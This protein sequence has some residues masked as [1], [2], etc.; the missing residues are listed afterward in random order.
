MYL[1][2]VLTAL[3][4]IAGLLLPQVV[5]AADE[6][7]MGGDAFSYNIRAL[8]FS[9]AQYPAHS[10]QNPD[11]AFLDLHRY[12]AAIELRP[13]LFFDS[14][15]FGALFKPRLTSTSRW[16]EDGGS[17]GGRDNLTRAFVNEW[18]V[19]AKPH[20][21]LFLSFGKEK[22]LWGPS[23]LAS[24]SNILFKDTER[25][26]PK[27]EVEGIHLVRMVYLPSAALTITALSETQKDPA[28]PQVNDHPVRALKADW[29][30][31]S[32]AVSV[33]GYAKRDD[34]FRFGSYGQWTASDAVL[35]YYDG[36][37]SRGTDAL[38]PLN[39]PSNLLGGTFVRR[40]EDTSRLYPIATAGGSYTF[41]SGSTLNLEFL[42]NGAGYND[43]EASD[44]YRLRRNAADHF[45]DGGLMTGLSRKT[46]ADALAPGM[47]FLRRY[48]LM[49]QFQVREIRNALDIV[50]RYVHGIEERAGQASTILEWRFSDR[51]QLFNV[52][53]TSVARGKEAEFN[54]VLVRS[55]M[56]GIEAHF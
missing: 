53:T 56:A 25:A 49:G 18:R 50:V 19:Q 46:L 33:I 39:D 8:L 35:L 38:Y 15:S 37:V 48:Y 31:A 21:S 24:P 6:T 45:F 54:A 9:E 7:A 13:D 29:V 17:K 55:F 14:P 44:Y 30:G 51:V 23:F 47:P 1:M 20:D 36:I 27:T 10:S 34:R 41:L 22:L 4:A 26:N 43:S 42:Y 40:D 32:A 52:N 16:W 28:V 11:N 2:S 12:A 5:H 3:V